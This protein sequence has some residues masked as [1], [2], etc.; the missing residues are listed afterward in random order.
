[1][2]GAPPPANQSTG[3]AAAIRLSRDAASG[4][5]RPFSVPPIVS[6]VVNS[7]GEPLD[8][9]TRAFMEPRFGHEF[10][11]VRIHRDEQAVASARSV[12]ARA[13]TVGS[14]IV[15]GAG[16]YAPSAAAGKQLLAHEMAHVLQQRGSGMAAIQRREGTYPNPSAPLEYK[17]D[18]YEFPYTVLKPTKLN[19]KGPFSAA[20]LDLISGVYT[21]VPKT[22]S[23]V[24]RGSTADL[25]VAARLGARHARAILK[26]LESSPE[27]VDI[28]AQL[29]VF[30]AD[31][32]NPGFRI[33]EPMDV[34][35]AGSKFVRA[36]VPYRAGRNE[37]AYVDDVDVIMIDESVN[38]RMKGADSSLTEAQVA[39]AF[40]DALVHEAV[41]A[42]R[43]VSNLSKGGLKGSIDEEL[44]TR[45]KS[46][47]ILTEMSNASSQPGVKNE[48]A[49]Y[50]KDIGADTLTRK[51]VALSVVSGDKVTYL[52]SFFVD[53]AF[54]EFF[55]QYAKSS[56][57]LIPGLTDLV[58]PSAVTRGTAAGHAKEVRALIE[59][60]SEP[61]DVLVDRD[62]SL[63]EE[64]AGVVPPARV[65]TLP[66]VIGAAESGRLIDLLGRTGSLSD[67]RSESKDMKRLSP[68]GRAVL[69]HVL[70]MQ[71]VLIKESLKEEHEAAG[72]GLGS[73]AHE[74]LSN[75]LA[76][77]Y[78]GETRAYDALK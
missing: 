1:V 53:S 78:L 60:F 63:R 77:K 19:P 74:D 18:K 61:R 71:T 16:E 23:P 39:V 69:F 13:Y 6:D 73:K 42:F 26:L 59:R 15:F 76:K 51:Q 7:P 4:P 40:V 8:S 46:S 47:A 52:E 29:D 34:L 37:R 21:D 70:V 5:Q 45:Q 28:A 36:G 32:K 54:G 67:L 10:A 33:F 11:H 68:A 75:D 24:G 58:H 17:G 25:C 65:K 49:A 43:R 27:F 35:K 55:E 22:C 56:P 48:F 14:H 9:G 44:A 66:P 31:D 2:L 12:N 72:L 41:H 62:T 20:V 50:V 30:Y 64:A 57:G 38:P 3:T